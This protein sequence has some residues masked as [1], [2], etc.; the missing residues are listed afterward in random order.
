MFASYLLHLLPDDT[1]EDQVQELMQ[2]L[3]PNL[4]HELEG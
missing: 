3:G 4:M 2:L 1:T